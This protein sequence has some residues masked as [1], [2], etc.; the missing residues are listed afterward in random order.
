M[1]DVYR[2]ERKTQCAHKPGRSP[3]DIPSQEVDN[4]E[5]KHPEQDGQGSDHD[6][7]RAQDPAE[8]VLYDVVQGGRVRI[9]VPCQFETRAQ[10]RSPQAHEPV[11]VIPPHGLRIEP[12]GP[13]ED[14]QDDEQNDPD[15][16]RKRGGLRVLTLCVCRGICVHRACSPETVP[17][18]WPHSRAP[19]KDVDESP[20]GLLSGRGRTASKRSV[21]DAR[22]DSK[23][24]EATRRALA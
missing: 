8:P 9:D 24:E 11:V 1:V 6:G 22:Q 5:G 21:Q 18:A 15:G 19:S 10:I 3:V 4:R 2:R 20:Q 17:R 7:R 12:V 16:R 13:D 23:R 14:K